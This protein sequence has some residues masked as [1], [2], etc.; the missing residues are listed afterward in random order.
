MAD[1]VGARYF[2]RETVLAF[3]LDVL[4][5]VIF[6]SIGRSAHRHGITVSGMAS[7]LWPFAIGLSTSW[8]VVELLRVRPTSLRAALIVVLSTVTVGM[9]LRV[10]AG[11]GTAVAFILVALVFLGAT[12]TGWRLA[13]NEVKR[14]HSRH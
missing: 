8:V 3:A 11:Q 14:R 7:T 4:D 2:G 13:Y 9:V 10:I 1:L 12:M 6:V 5:L